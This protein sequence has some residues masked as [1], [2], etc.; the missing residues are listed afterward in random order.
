MDSYGPTIHHYQ[1]LLVLIV[2]K[3]IV[4]TRKITIIYTRK[5]NQDHP[6]TNFL[7]FCTWSRGIRG[8]KYSNKW[9]PGPGHGSAV[10][11]PEIAG[12]C[13]PPSATFV[14]HACHLW[15][16]E[17]CWTMLNYSN[18]FHSF[19][20]VFIRFSVFSSRKPAGTHVSGK[21]LLHCPMVHRIDDQ[22]TLRTTTTSSSSPHSSQFW[23][24]WDS[25]DGWWWLTI[26]V[27]NGNQFEL[28]V[29]HGWSWLIIIDDGFTV[30]ADSWLNKKI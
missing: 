22:N 1:P 25:T 6:H 20:V 11:L 16:V 5:P 10:H 30:L 15:I 21:L 26:L 19:T 9:T 2:I 12:M 28:I 14:C 4:C 18:L 27:D 24:D 3:G 7:P 23:D 8:S 17:L 13:N 29:I